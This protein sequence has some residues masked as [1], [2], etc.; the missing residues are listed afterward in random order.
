MLL[1]IDQGAVVTLNAARPELWFTQSTAALY[2]VMTDNAFR[3][4]AAAA[5]QRIGAS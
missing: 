3:I 2:H 4:G 5:G 1:V